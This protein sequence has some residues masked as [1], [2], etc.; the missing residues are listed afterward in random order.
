MIDKPYCKEHYSECLCSR[1]RHDFENCCG[2]GTLFKSYPCPLK[3]CSVF[4]EK[5]VKRGD[6]NDVEAI[7]QSAPEP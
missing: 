2:R 3:Q 6:D 7:P 5:P 4:R 1:C